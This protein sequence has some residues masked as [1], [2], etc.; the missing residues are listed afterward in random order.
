MTD[1]VIGDIQGCYTALQCLLERLKFD[2]A[3]DQLWCVGDLVNRGAH[4]VECLRFLKSVKARVVL[5]NHDLHLLAL[6]YASQKSAP[7]RKDT[8]AD[9]LAADDCEELLV[10]LKA[11]P[12]MIWLPERNVALSHAGI[13]HIWSTEKALAL[14][15]EVEAVLQSD[16]CA[17]YFD[18]MYGNDPE[19]WSESLQG[20]ARWRVI[21]N[22]FTRM[23]FV[24]AQGRLE[25]LAKETVDTAPSGYAPWFRYPRKDNCQMLFGHWAAL[26]GHT[27]VGGM[28]ALDTGCVWGGALTALNLDTFERTECRCDA[29]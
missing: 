28:H 11:Q 23:R 25:L 27:G 7:R 26:S 10:W 8:L 24:D 16:Q 13:P 12:L 29:P 21:T 22:Y 18:H 19:V 2:P 9:V 6:F 14:A 1:Y 5:G 3:K 20:E 15:K 4:N 17:R